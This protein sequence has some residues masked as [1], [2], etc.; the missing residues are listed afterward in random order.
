MTTGY[1]LI[2]DDDPDAREIQVDLVQSLGL[3]ARVAEDGMEALRLVQEQAPALILLDIMMPR[4]NG[5]AV[6]AKLRSTQASRRIPVIIV[7]ACGLDDR[8]TLLLPGVVDVV[9]KGSINVDQFRALLT[10]TLMPNHRAVTAVHHTSNITPAE[11][12]GKPA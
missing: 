5:F 7:T 9:V 10:R 6:L 11:P 3:E 1:I 4:M 12:A 8:A 2:V